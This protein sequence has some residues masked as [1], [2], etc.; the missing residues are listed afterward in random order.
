MQPL[1]CILWNATSGK[2]WTIPE[3]GKLTSKI[4]YSELFGIIEHV[5]DLF[6]IVRSELSIFSPCTVHAPIVAI[7]DVCAENAKYKTNK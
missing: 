6:A 7:N 3:L 1:E 5:L 4:N 2:L